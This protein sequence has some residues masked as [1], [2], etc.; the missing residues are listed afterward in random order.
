LQPRLS[1]KLKYGRKD[2]TSTALRRVEFDQIVSLWRS[3]IRIR[4]GSVSG[5]K[6]GRLGRAEPL[7]D[8]LSVSDAQIVKAANR[9]AADGKYAIAA[10]VS[11]WLT[12][13]WSGR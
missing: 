7:V 1:W 5:T 9:V 12:F 4:F 6:T 3:Q 13:P 8:Y 11:A 10:R 2:E